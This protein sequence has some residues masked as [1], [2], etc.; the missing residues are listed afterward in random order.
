MP[1]TFRSSKKKR[2]LLEAYYD[3]GRE[4]SG[5]NV[6]D[7]VLEG[8]ERGVGEVLIT[9]VDRDG[10]RKGPDIQLIQCSERFTGV[11][12]SLAGVLA[13]QNIAQM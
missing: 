1:R 5:V 8:Q 6:V 2:S 3:N 9:S 12:S 4:P 7:W 11:P 10:T 13:H